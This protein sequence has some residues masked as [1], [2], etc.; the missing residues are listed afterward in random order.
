MKAEDIFLAALEQT[1]PAGRQA[2]LSSACGH[3]ARLRANVEG[4]LHSHEQAG[5]FL[6]APLLDLPPT[7]DD[8]GNSTAGPAKKQ[9][10]I[11]LDFL[12]PS[13]DQEALGRIGPYDVTAFVGRGGMGVV[14]RARDAK[15]NR[16]VAIK[17]MAPE[18]ASNPTARKRFVREAQAAAAVV[19]QHVVTIHAV[20]EDRLPYLVMEYIAGQSLQ[21]KIDR[22]GHL[23]LVEILR[24]GQQIAAGLAAAHAH[25]LIHRDVKPA[26]ILLEN[27]VERVRI[28]D[29]GLARAVDDVSMSRTG[30]VAGTPQYMSPEQAQ[31]LALD[32]RSD[33]FS[34]GCVLYAMCTGRPPFRAE[35]T[36]AALRRVCEDVPR[37]IREVNPEIPQWLV[38]IIDHLLAKQPAERIQSAQEVAELLSQCL[39]AVQHS[40]LLGQASNLPVIHSAGKRNVRG[41]VSYRP[42]RQWLIAAVVM[43][44]FVVSGLS[45][46][47]AMGVTS[48]AATAIRIMTPGGTLVVETDDPA[49][50]VTIEG[51]GGLTITGAGPQ[52]V[53]LR[54]GSYRLRADKDGKPL[55]PD[56]DVVS[57]LRGDKQVVRVRLEGDAQVG[58]APP[59]AESGAFVLLGGAGVAERKFDTL[60]E[61]VQGA[62]DGDTVE[63]RG[64]GP[65]M[66]GPIKLPPAAL[67][68]RAGDGCRPV[69]ETG[70]DAWDTNE[71]IWAHGPLAL[72]G[73][74]FRGTKTGLRDGSVNAVK[75]DAYSPLFVT[76]CRFV[77]LGSRVNPIHAGRSTNC[78]VRHCEFVLGRIANQAVVWIPGK[79]RRLVVHGCIVA[80]R[81]LGLDLGY[82]AAPAEPCRVE[83][84]RNT[85]AGDWSINLARWSD[86]AARGRPLYL[87]VAENVNDCST[88]MTLSDRPETPPLAP[89]AA[90]AFVRELVAY[91][92]ERNVHA[93]GGPLLWYTGKKWTELSSDRTVNDAETWQRFWEDAVSSSLQGNVRFH[94][95]NLRPRTEESLEALTRDD[96]RLREGSAGYRAGLDGKDLGADVDL[97]G[98]GAAYERWKKTPEY[99]RWLKETGQNVSPGVAWRGWPENAPPPAVAPFDSVQAKAHQ[100]AWAKHLNV[101]VEQT[102][103]LGMHLA[104]IPPGEFTM[105]TPHEVTSQIVASAG[106]M[107][108][109]HESVA[110]GNESAPHRVR[111]T[112][113]FLLGKFEVTHGQ[114]RRFVETTG[115]KTLV[116]RNGLG[117]WS[118]FQGKWVRRPEH[119]WSTPGEWEIVDDEPVCHVAWDDARAFCGWLSEIEGRP[120]ALPTEAQ[121]E[122]ACRA[123]TTGSTYA[124]TTDERGDIAWTSDLLGQIDSASHR[125]QPVGRKQPNA[126]GLYDMLGNVWEF[127]SDYYGPSPS[128]SNLR[129]DPTG[130]AQGDLHVLRGGAW[131]RSGRLFARC[132][133]RLYADAD[134]TTDAG[135]GFRVCVTGDL[136][137]LSNQKERPASAPDE[138]EKELE[139]KTSAAVGATTRVELAKWQGEWE[140]A[141][142]GRLVI[143]GE[144]WSSYPKRGVEVLSTI[145]IVEVADEMTYILLLN[146]GIDGQVRTIQT[147]LRVDGDTLHNCG[148]IGSVRPTEFVNKPGFIYTQWKRVT[149]PQP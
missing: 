22:E 47:E 117:G 78:E 16:V 76:H 129:T 72:E 132:G 51:D 53:R 144:R 97:V 9:D 14:L 41:R 85:V 40:S 87:R 57:I 26:N 134:D 4:L 20:D 92:E 13:E 93:A 146:G 21:E 145:K 6:N 48:L 7:I 122:H 35:T 114:F 23:K 102:N 68:I 113:P 27:G 135:I 130:P 55:H 103:S 49:V 124:V 73:L 12:A 17:V 8:S 24:I 15:L 110:I 84:T 121:W 105:G 101:S 136:P 69:I 90:L 33:L 34:L 62:S 107:V 25:G 11:P 133:A 1:T 19:H 95:G 60:A 123:G 99:Q 71:W 108:M 96:F 65:F 137:L 116:E 44:V 147:I 61:A 106:R 115:Y 79:D 31:G 91:Q 100:Q 36:I 64:N 149:T 37:P 89:T 112:K 83:F 38:E 88:F 63:I 74:T 127:C 70:P 2:Y 86:V 32:A 80:G 28:T 142:H 148:T 119:V 140:N 54:P 94:G 75:V 109:P 104:L 128:R 141:V 29:F 126:F 111:L 52:E 81:G 39:A 143:N 50:K 43:L 131:Y 30:D 82:R 3:D 45:M 98:P 66:T 125:P 46:T 59:T 18:L 10:E 5:S 120:Y 67:A 118:N 58:A 138:N 139:P 77:F 56:R 42:S